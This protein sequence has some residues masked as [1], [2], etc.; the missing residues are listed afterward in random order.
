MWCQNYLCNRLPIKTYWAM[1]SIP[2]GE[3]AYIY[4]LTIL[5]DKIQ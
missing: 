4:Q 2:E 3:I 1:V 5:F